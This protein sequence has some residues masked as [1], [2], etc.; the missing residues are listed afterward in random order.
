M[1]EVELKPFD[2]QFHADPYPVYRWLRDQA[3]CYR[4]DELGFY[5]LS[6]YAD[7]LEASQQPLLFSSAQGTTLELLDTSSLLPMMIFMDPPDHDD[8]R[9]LVGR[10][11]SA[12]ALSDVEPYVRRYAIE[13]LE[14]LDESGGGDFV[15]EF[16][17]RLPSNVIM[18]LLGVPP[19]DRN[20]L[21]QWI[22][23]SLE[24]AEEPPYIRN[25]AIRAMIEASEYWRALVSE[26]RRHPDDKLMSSLC[27]V[28][29]ETSGCGRTKL[30]DDEVV[31]F[32]SLIGSA[33][34]ETLT[35]L[36]ASAVVL[37]HR[38]PDQ[39][40]KVLEDRSVVPSAVEE[41]LRY[42]APS[43]YQGRVLTDSVSLH[44]QTMPK[45]SRVL[46][47]TGSANRDEREYPD[48]DRFDVERPSHLALGFGHGLHFCLGAALARL[49]G[50]IALEEF[51]DRF[52]SYEI[53]EAKLRRV[54]MS[55]V[56]GFA[57]VPFR[58]T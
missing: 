27:E 33:G 15:E 38:H 13:L 10:A 57:S 23:A 3:P 54:H 17:A 9:R 34:T 58:K 22:D 53:D 25:E 2:H 4:N 49:E 46:L 42:W 41:T 56:H 12:R 20:T 32:C 45:G 51:A 19:A 39:W 28:E 31:G 35:K 21:R 47:L 55:N 1:W 11:F 44:G 50:R 14:R 48:P 40:E 5:A 6:R 24:R 16:S 36:L 8:H 7:V 52:P 37:F 29:V 18:E 43:Q 26:K 30:T